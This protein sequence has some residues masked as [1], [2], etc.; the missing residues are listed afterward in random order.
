VWLASRAEEIMHKCRLGG[1]LL[2]AGMLASADI[3]RAQSWEHLEG[4]DLYSAFR[5]H[6]LQYDNGAVQRF[7]GSG[8]TEYRK[9]NAWNIDGLWW[10]DANL[11][12]FVL[13]PGN[14]DCYKVRRHS[15]GLELKLEAEHGGT[16]RLRYR[17]EK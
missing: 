9:P 5:S 1:L 14:T 4:E 3:G 6:E 8:R 10:V 15:D 2:L 11:L 12:C 17:D 7:D 16:V 13:T